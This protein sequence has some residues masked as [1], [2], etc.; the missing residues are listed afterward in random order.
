MSDFLTGLAARSF[1]T[2]AAIRPRLTSLFEPIRNDAARRGMPGE[3]REE[4]AIPKDVELETENPRNRKTG[5]HRSQVFRDDDAQGPDGA[6]TGTEPGAMSA[7][8]HSK[9][10]ND[11]PL[12]GSVP[13]ET[14][15]QI[16]PLGPT[17]P[18]HDR[19][20]SSSEEKS[21]RNPAQA[22][23]LDIEAGAP[24]HS[25]VM[26]PVV[27][28]PER[29]MERTPELLI[30]PRIVPELRLA[31]L[32]LSARV[33]SQ[34]RERT[35]SVPAE[36]VQPEPNI[37]VTIGR[38]EVHASRETGRV[39]RMPAAS[40]VMGLDEYLRGRETRRP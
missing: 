12:R 25:A 34:P 26:A 11:E 40:P 32:A 4:A 6:R 29:N 1:G 35:P 19:D 31:D 30:A 9:Q 18:S 22:P 23:S 21:D 37:Q 10:N 8:A 36:P 3:L 38:I 27:S 5:R 13:V 39:S 20:V 33:G 2:A 14:A 16:G 7:L 17:S 15:V 28:E 24:R